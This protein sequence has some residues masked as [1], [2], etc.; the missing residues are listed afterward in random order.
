[1]KNIMFQN[2]PLSL[3]TFI[4]QHINNNRFYSDTFIE[5][6][7]EVTYQQQK[8]TSWYFFMCQALKQESIIITAYSKRW[9]ILKRLR[10]LVILI[11]WLKF[12]VI[13]RGCIDYTRGGEGVSYVERKK[14]STVTYCLSQGS[15][16]PAGWYLL[17]TSGC[18]V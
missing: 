18:P 7:P 4:Y 12:H 3:L 13:I 11:I 5:S 6:H 15:L 8:S 14:P 10:W 16:G 2:I 1:M 17:A 9:T